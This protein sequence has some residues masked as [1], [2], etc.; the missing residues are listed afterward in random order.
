MRYTMRTLVV[1]LMSVALLIHP[2]AAWYGGCGCGSYEPVHYGPLH[3]GCCG[4]VVVYDNCGCGPCGGETIE[5]PASEPMPKPAPAA[6]G[7]EDLRPSAPATQPRATGRP[8]ERQPLPPA[9]P[10]EEPDSL[11][12]GTEEAAPPEME[13]PE[14]P[15]EDPADLFGEPAEPTPPA[16]TEPAEEP[17]D[18]PFDLFGEPDESEP[19]MPA[20]EEPAEDS[21]DLDDIFGATRGVLREAGGLASEEMRVWIDNTGNFSTRGRLL[22]LLEGHV[23]LLKDNGRTTTVPLYR[24]SQSDLEFVYRQARAQQDAAYQTAQ[25]SASLPLSAN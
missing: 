11:F 25:A 22:S 16:E 12:N 1:A 10:A 17:A 15:A 14:P 6:P 3:D 9:Q 23:R 20:E 7:D 18:E 2:A 19:E 4:E 8:A 13:Q 5:A 24:L 21:E